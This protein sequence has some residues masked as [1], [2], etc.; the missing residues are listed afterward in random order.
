MFDYSLSVG[1]DH[2][3]HCSLVSII[4]NNV[5]KRPITHYKIPALVKVNSGS[6]LSRVIRSCV[7]IGS[8]NLKASAAKQ[9]WHLKNFANIL[10]FQIRQRVEFKCSLKEKNVIYIYY[11]QN[12]DIVIVIPFLMEM[13]FRFLQL[14]SSY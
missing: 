3:C 1:Q 9:K 8:R 4:D 13:G 12:I 5:Y 7:L 10:K 14:N 2:V 11:V 6:G